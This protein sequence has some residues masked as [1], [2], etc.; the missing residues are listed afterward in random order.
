[1]E[2]FGP[3]ADRVAAGLRKGNQVVVE[4]KLRTDSWET[5]DGAK[6]KDVRVS[7]LCRPQG[8]GDHSV[9][10]RA[11]CSLCEAI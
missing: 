3:L 9:A 7:Q 8:T 6:R 4:G 5:K 10:A 11:R 2:A 1:M